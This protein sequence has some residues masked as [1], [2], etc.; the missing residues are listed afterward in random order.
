MTKKQTGKLPTTVASDGVT[1][2]VTMILADTTPPGNRQSR[3]GLPSRDTRRI[4]SPFG[5]FEGWRVLEPALP[6]TLSGQWEG[7]WAWPVLV[8]HV[9]QHRLRVPCRQGVPEGFSATALPAARRLLRHWSLSGGRRFL[10]VG[11]LAS[12][13][14][15]RFRKLP[16]CLAGGALT[17]C[18]RRPHLCGTSSPAFVTSSTART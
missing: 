5:R 12:D 7:P 10:S 15:P 4:A 9:T 11:R 13:R 18:R 17:T 1:E 14:Q 8:A 6:A 2:M 3:S 16:F